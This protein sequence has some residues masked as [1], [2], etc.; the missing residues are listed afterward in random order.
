MDSLDSVTDFPLQSS[1]CRRR[2]KMKRTLNSRS[3]PWATLGTSSLRQRETDHKGPLPGLSVRP[4]SP[5]YCS[6]MFRPTIWRLTAGSR[7]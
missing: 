5:F 7:W 4:L 2:L 3:G 6:G 1:L